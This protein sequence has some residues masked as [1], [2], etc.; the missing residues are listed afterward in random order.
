MPKKTLALIFPFLFLCGG[1]LLAALADDMRLAM[2]KRDYA[3]AVAMSEGEKNPDILLFRANALRFQG[4]FAEAI[5][6]YTRVLSARNAVNERAKASYGK[7]Q[8][9]ISLKRFGE[10]AEILQGELVRLGET[11]RAS[12]QV[13]ILMNMADE[14]SSPDEAGDTKPNYARAMELYTSALDYDNLPADLQYRLRVS[15]AKCRIALRNMAA[16]RTQ[17]TEFEDMLAKTPRG[18]TRRDAELRYYLGK[19]QHLLGNMDAAEHHLAIAARA[20]ADAGLALLAADALLD[21]LIFPPPKPTDML[22]SS[23]RIVIDRTAIRRGRIIMREVIARNPKDPKSGELL[24]RVGKAERDADDNANAIASFT[25]YAAKWPDAENAPEAIWHIAELQFSQNQH[26]E[27]IRLLRDL[28][29]KYPGSKFWQQAQA[30]IIRAEYDEAG[31]AYANEDYAQ[32]EHLW[33]GFIARYPLDENA[34]VAGLRA[35]YCMEQRKEKERAVIWWDEVYRRWPQNESGKDASYQA[36]RILADDLDNYDKAIIFLQRIKSGAWEN[37]AQARIAELNTEFLSLSTEK[38]FT[39]KTPVSLALKTRNVEKLRVRM[40]KLDSE[41][42]FRAQGN[43]SGVENIDV[44][45]IAPDREFIH[46]VADYTKHR[47]SAARLPIE[48]TDAGSWV[49]QIASDTLQASTLLVISDIALVARASQGRVFVHTSSLAS[50]RARPGVSILIANGTAIIASGETAADGSFTYTGEDEQAAGMISVFAKQG[51]HIAAVSPGWFDQTYKM[52]PEL[53]S[54]LVCDRQAYRAG[55]TIRFRV[56]LRLRDAFGSFTLPV[57]E[58]ALTLTSP[59]GQTILKKTVRTDEFG[60]IHDEARLDAAEPP[61]NCTLLL[62]ANTDSKINA[63]HA[64]RVEQYQ[65]KETEV[66]FTQ[67]PLVPLPGDTIRITASVTHLFGLAAGGREVLWRAGQEDWQSGITDAAGVLPISIE[68][69]ERSGSRPIWVSVQPSWENREYRHQ[70]QFAQNDFSLELRALRP[71]WLENEK[72]KLTV[73]VTPILGADAVRK[74][75][76]QAERIGARQTQEITKREISTDAQGKASIELPSLPSG[77]YAIT[78]SALAKNGERIESGLR[79]VSSGAQDPNKIYILSDAEELESGREARVRVFSRLERA[80]TALVSYESHRMLRQQSV[81]LPLGASTISLTPGEEFAPRFRM[82][83]DA[84]TADGFHTANAEFAL[85]HKLEIEL[86]TGRAKP[87]PGMTVPLAISAKTSDGR[88]RRASIFLFVIDDAIYSAVQNTQ[89]DIIA[90]F[91]PEYALADARSASFTPFAYTASTA[92]RDKNIAALERQRADEEFKRKAPMEEDFAL[93]RN[94]SLEF[95]RSRLAAGTTLAE[96]DLAKGGGDGSGGDDGSAPDT[97]LAFLSAHAFFQNAVITDANGNANVNIPLPNM[98]TRWRIVA[99]AADTSSHFGNADKT[100]DAVGESFAKISPPEGI[101]AGDTVRIPVRLA[102]ISAAS[103][104]TLAWSI[105]DA[106]RKSIASGSLPYDLRTAGSTEVYIPFTARAAGEYFVRTTTPGFAAAAAISV[107]PSEEKRVIGASGLVQSAWQKEIKYTAGSKNRILTIRVGSPEAILEANPPFIGMGSLSGEIAQ[108][109]RSIA[110][111]EYQKA[112]RPDGAT[113]PGNQSAARISS[114]LEHFAV[115]QQTEWRRTPPPASDLAWLGFALQ[116][117]RAI[118][119]SPSAPLSSWVRTMLE[120]VFAESE[121]I[122][123]KALALFGLAGAGENSFAWMNRLYRDRETLENRELALLALAIHA[124]AN[125]RADMTSVLADQLAA[126]FKRENGQASLSGTGISRSRF[127]SQPSSATALGALALISIAPDDAQKRAVVGEALAWLNADAV[128]GCWRIPAENGLIPLVHA[129]YL[130]SETAANIWQAYVRL[131]GQNAGVLRNLS[132]MSVITVRDADLAADTARVEISLD[133]RGACFVLL[134]SE[135]TLPQ[136][137]RPQNDF[138]GSFELR[139]L[140]PPYIFEGRALDRGMSIAQ[141]AADAPK[142]ELRR[143]ARGKRFDIEMEIS[144]SEDIEDNVVCAELALP[145]GCALL[146]DSG[147]AKN[148]IYRETA[149]GIARYL[150][151]VIP[152]QKKIII[153]ESVT[154]NTEGEFSFPGARCY[155][156]ALPWKRTTTNARRLSVL[157]AEADTQADYVFSADELFT[158]G[159]IYYERADYARASKMLEECM[160]R[161]PIKAI[162]ARSITEMLLDI[163]IRENNA[164]EI[165]RLFESLKERYSDYIISLPQAELVAKAY[166]RLGELERACQVL[167]GVI[168]ARFVRESAVSGALL[169]VGKIREASEFLRALVREYPDGNEELAALASLAQQLFPLAATRAALGQ[170]GQNL[171]KDWLYA[172]SFAMF[173]EVLAALPETLLAQEAAFT[174]ATFLFELERYAE[175]MEHTQNAL[176]AYT[177][178]HFKDSFEYLCA[179]A[180]FFE[181]R[182]EE[183][184]KAC[185]ALAESRYPQLNGGEGASRYRDY[186]LFM[187]AKIRHSEQRYD[188]AMRLYDQIKYRFR[189][190]RN[191]MDYLKNKYISLPEI[192]RIIPGEEAKLRI[193][194]RNIQKASLELYKVDFLI[195]CLKQRDL[196]TVRDV[197]L[198][199][200]RPSLSTQISLGDGQDGMTA[201]HETMIPLPP[202][203]SGAWLIVVKGDGFQQSG[204]IIRSNLVLDS[205][206]MEDGTIRASAHDRVS[207]KPLQGVSVRFI[208]AGGD[209][210]ITVATDPR[211]IAEGRMAGVMTIAAEYNGEY[212]F[213]RIGQPGIVQ[214]PRPRPAVKADE[215]YGYK[216][217]AME[218]VM[219][220]RNTLQQENRERWQNNQMTEHQGLELRNLKW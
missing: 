61:G 137:A 201:V 220:Y 71:I 167:D 123:V 32:A 177:N 59:S 100:M 102:R 84:A 52:V 168:E 214:L 179:G 94:E 85:K 49:V 24:F 53:R 182:F 108:L 1:G 126:R 180:L 188:E 20:S 27:A 155:P 187:L 48:I 78:A 44:D 130:K 144:A 166:T 176:A 82:T 115:L 131:N 114:A 62:T 55:D 91:F 105:E 33:T 216:E 39:E 92:G 21:V 173:D 118:G 17:K 132:N 75:S 162:P 159:K 56:T 189:D 142:N 96:M 195:L 28:L 88:G 151:P 68:S 50:G 15:R 11:A 121:S 42:C 184:G 60:T 98:P 134:E 110:A 185:L 157:S 156:L 25:E 112:I 79:I 69:G 208:P 97:V 6:A 165:V 41:A 26:S 127:L 70:I 148:A 89:P 198:R 99:C 43:L 175:V 35:G 4:K 170:S 107:L 120:R 194:S 153:R 37:A 45:L 74:I 67:T 117:S 54:H 77:E 7:A 135:E 160:A 215:S 197:N 210:A 19:T 206:I 161:W 139:L 122:E 34:P 51:D 141:S 145:A 87:E 80:Q 174:K 8:S 209:T 147:S 172:E 64:I 212:A 46:T 3:Q 150:I 111:L 29:A 149:P 14:L 140:H 183:A 90:S 66:R 196:T 133:G 190:A 36:A 129:R 104:G 202:E 9:L 2:Q 143:I 23:P 128:F 136:E 38:I 192:T 18:D 30:L 211:G 81:L 57:D 207:K 154:A 40:Y 181:Q 119:I 200:I 218:E 152:G 217:E 163:A 199:G 72:P 138:Q 83:I 31:R 5:E 86:N 205:M 169:S 65:P 103:R 95:G 101:R 204:M 191:S 93:D 164:R 193:E 13:L 146:P 158:L 47:L 203:E 219:E 178:S 113:L 213:R 76:I 58:Y 125:S 10:A 124:G 63:R 22:R 106:E 171:T 116:E 73:T 109:V 186:A 16:L 12:A